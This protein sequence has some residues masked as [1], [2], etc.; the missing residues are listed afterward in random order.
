MVQQ[1]LSQAGAFSNDNINAINSNFSE[2]YT[3][4]QAATITAATTI[5]AALYANKTIIV[6][7]AAGIAIILPPAT[8]TG[9]SYD[10]QIGTTITSVGTT[11]TTGVTGTGCDSYEGVALQSGTSVTA[12]NTAAPG[13]TT[14]SDVITLNG[15]TTGGFIGDTISLKDIATGIWQLKMVTKTSGTAATPFSHT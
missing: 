2:F 3:G 7:S 5:T 4:R 12:F 1:I 9:T 14:G 8:G 11:I 15:T 10:F 13:S 6:N